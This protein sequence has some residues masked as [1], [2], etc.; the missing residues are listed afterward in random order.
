MLFMDLEYPMWQYTK[1]TI[2]KENDQKYNFIALGDSRIKS[3]FVPAEFDDKEFNS[4]NMALGGSSA[5]EGYYSLKTYLENNEAPEHLLLGYSPG[6]LRWNIFYWNR[7]ANFQYLR[8]P[9]FAEVSHYSETI[10]NYATLGED[11]YMDIQIYTGKYFTQFL[12][13]M[14]EM[15]WNENF[16]MYEHL[17]QS[18]GHV[19]FGRADYSD[20]VT[21]EVTEPDFAPSKILDFYLVRLFELAK[22]HDIKTYWYCPPINRAS[23]DKVTEDYNKDFNNYL[24]S[25][26]VNYDLTILRSLHAMENKY[27][28]D[29]YHV[30]EEGASLV[31]QSIKKHFLATQASP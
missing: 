28:G 4:F 18:K 10:D 17:Q 7:T 22:E 31:T 24:K 27:F 8:N 20:E 3:A 19:F 12:N 9:E 5:I 15:R 16:A 14:T 26:E 2:N 21:V 11:D 13:G 25:Y 1:H 6:M 30:Y 29:Q 23:M